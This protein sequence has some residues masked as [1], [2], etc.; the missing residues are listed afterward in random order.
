MALYMKILDAI[1][2]LEEYSVFEK[3]EN[4]KI[5]DFIKHW[6]ERLKEDI[7]K[8][9][10][11]EFYYYPESMGKCDINQ[12][13]DIL[14]E[15]NE[16]FKIIA[17]ED[18]KYVPIQSTSPAIKTMVDEVVSLLSD[19][20]KVG[21]VYYKTISEYNFTESKM[22]RPNYNSY[23]TKEV[24]TMIGG[25]PNVLSMTIIY[26]DNPLMWPLIF[27]EYGHTVFKRIKSKSKYQKIHSKLRVHCGD[28][29][30]DIDPS[31]LNTPASV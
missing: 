18:M 28:A 15:K 16:A 17:G 26:H 6:L 21:N 2:Y 24:E 3:S 31:K 14:N 20:I 1:D 23:A 13:S 11:S 22:R 10:L 29:K 19:E 25:R 7:T 5:L 30:I 9:I 8:E 12:I 4:Q 27:H